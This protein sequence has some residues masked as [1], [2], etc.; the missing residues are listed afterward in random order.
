M[1][2][3]ETKINR[4][5]SDGQEYVWKKKGEGLISREVKDTVKF[6]GGSLMVWGCIGWN[7]VGVLSEVEG[8][9]DAEQYVAILEE[10]LLQSMEESGIPQD[11]IIFQPDNDPKH[12]SRRAQKWFEEQG[13]KILDWPAQSPD[14][15]PIEYTW[16]CLKRCLSGY[17]NAPKGVH[18][19]WERVV[20]QWG[21]ISVEECQMWIES[22][23][24]GIQA[25]IKAKGG[26]TKY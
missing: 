11:D 16:N 4:I 6:G 18:Q 2:S 3:D 26:H 8:R 14:L 7:G 12:T 25:V 20:E 17:S 1:W 21:K 13:I 24:R 5:G 9:M 22:M 23:P 19:L 15:N 10:G